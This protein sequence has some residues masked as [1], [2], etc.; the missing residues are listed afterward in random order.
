M[1]LPAQLYRQFDADYSRDVPGEGYG[2]WHDVE[3]ELAPAH[4]ALVVM[5]AWDSGQPGEFPG[6]RRAVEYTPRAEKILCDVFPPLLS[7]VRN[8]PL[9][10]FHVVGGRDYY[11]HLPGYVPTKPTP[12][13]QVAADPAYHALQQLRHDHATPGAHNA[14]DATAGFARL[15]FAPNARPLAHEGIA[16]NG[17]QLAA[18]C[19]AHGINHLIYVGFAINW[20]LLMSPG[21]MVDLK[22]HGCLCSTIAEAVTA[23]ENRETAREEREK[24]QALWRVA[25]EFGFVFNLPDF[26]KALPTLSQ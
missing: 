13:P 19:R 4:T 18:L 21:G 23:V 16:E 7:A 6:W 3:V 25:V 12:L 26:L 20:C 17:E 10:V 8:S 24:Q 11:S 15:D 2:G 14:A 22:R 5:H 9:P 1:K